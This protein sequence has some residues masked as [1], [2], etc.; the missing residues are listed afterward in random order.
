MLYL[1]QPPYIKEFIW[2][3][4]IIHSITPPAL[5]AQ[6]YQGTRSGSQGL[7]G[8]RNGEEPADKAVYG[9]WAGEA[10]WA[11]HIKQKQPIDI[12][13]SLIIVSNIHQV[14]T[15]Q[16]FSMVQSDEPYLQEKFLRLVEIEEEKKEQIKLK[17]WAGY[18]TEEKMRDT[19]K[20]SAS[21]PQ[22][23]LLSCI[24]SKQE[25]F[26]VHHDPSCCCTPF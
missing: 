19:L 5:G 20:Y 9:S 14:S 24:I 17:C 1:H 16:Y 25:R 12:Q 21:I 23:Y 18:A 15:G 3:I 22:K 6:D 8:R 10:D 26:H 13:W 4:H 2:F 7:D 11:T